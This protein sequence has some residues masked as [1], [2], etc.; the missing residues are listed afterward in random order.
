MDA[1]EIETTLLGMIAGFSTFL[2]PTELQEMRSLVNAGE[3]KVAFEN[4][5]TQLFE[6]DVTL[7]DETL[8]GLRTF[9][10]VMRIAPKYW[11]RLKI[12]E[13]ET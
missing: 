1:H 7:D 2:P 11:E 10:I 13:R 4:L 12:S 3:S 5:C 8:S 6:Y 9:G